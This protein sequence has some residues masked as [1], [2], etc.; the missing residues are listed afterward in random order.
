MKNILILTFLVTFFWDIILRI[1]AFS[2][3]PWK[4]QDFVESVVPYFEKHSVTKAAIFAG[5]VGLF[6]QMVILSIIDFP[7]ALS[8]VP[9]FL[10]VAF[11][12][13]GAV[14]YPIERLKL[15]PEL[16]ETY[17]KTLGRPRST[18]TDAYSGLV[19]ELSL[20]G[21]NML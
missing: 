21:L 11:F 17:Y 9:L 3:V 7:T 10:L 5:L 18:F 13:S 15:V 1:Y 19:V 6:T 20:L 8:Q 16:S 2:D 12:V 4:K 14:G